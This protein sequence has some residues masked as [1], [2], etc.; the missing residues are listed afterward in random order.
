MEI[1]QKKKNLCGTYKTH[2]QLRF[3]G[4]STGGN[5][6]RNIIVNKSQR[7]PLVEER[8]ADRWYY[9]NF[10][11]LLVKILYRKPVDYINTKFEC[12]EAASL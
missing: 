5:E 12:N 9:I 3:E 1:Q 6:K 11:I 10:L 8:I 2:R 7:T 4:N